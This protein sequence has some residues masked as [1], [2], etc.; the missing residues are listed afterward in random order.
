MVNKLQGITIIFKTLNMLSLKSNTTLHNSR[1]ASFLRFQE[2]ENIYTLSGNSQ[3]NHP[4]RQMQRNFVSE[5]LLKW[6]LGLKQKSGFL[7]SFS[8]PFIR[9]APSRTDQRSDLE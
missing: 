2:K 6:E 9:T 5:M 7:P 1:P 8:A 4:S 3:V